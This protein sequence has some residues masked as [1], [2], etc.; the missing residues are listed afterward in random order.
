MLDCGANPNEQVKFGNMET[1]APR[2]MNEIAKKG[3]LEIGLRYFSHQVWYLFH[4]HVEGLS[5]SSF[6]SPPESIDREL[7]CL[8]SLNT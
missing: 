2:V 3:S 6:P 4:L 5:L 7:Y 1:P 8:A